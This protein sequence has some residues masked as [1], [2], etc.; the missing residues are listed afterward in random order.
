[1]QS[2]NSYAPCKP[3]QLPVARELSAKTIVFLRLRLLGKS[4]ILVKRSF[5]WFDYRLVF[6]IVR[7]IEYLIRKPAQACQFRSRRRAC[8]FPSSFLIT[9]VTKVGVDAF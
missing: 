8:P 6:P 7:L 5:H 3:M 1:M 9:A 4:Q 2:R